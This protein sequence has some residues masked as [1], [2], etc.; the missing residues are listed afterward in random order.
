MSTPTCSKSFIGKASIQVI[1]FLFCVFSCFD[2]F[3]IFFSTN[4][5]WILSIVFTGQTPRRLFPPSVDLWSIGIL[6]HQV[7]TGKLAFTGQNVK[8]FFNLLKHKPSDTV[9]GYEL[10]NGDHCYVKLFAKIAAT[11]Q[12]VDVLKPV[13]LYCLQ[14]RKN[15]ASSNSYLYLFIVSNQQFFIL[16]NSQTWIHESIRFCCW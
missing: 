1:I 6:L 8:G 7:V 11:P 15:F 4:I 10:L 14:V 2:L 13:V 9:G 16:Q 12:L 3:S 5:Y